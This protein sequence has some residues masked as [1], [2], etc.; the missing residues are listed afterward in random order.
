VQVVH[1]P[2]EDVGVGLTRVER[3]RLAGIRERQH[4]Q[5]LEPAVPEV[6]RSARH[7]AIHEPV[8]LLRVRVDGARLAAG[9]LDDPEVAAASFWMPS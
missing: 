9:V 6:A 7:E 8:R 3:D 1:V 4:L 2:R 5:R